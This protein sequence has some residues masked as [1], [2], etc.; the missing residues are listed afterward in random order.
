M[1][2]EP[3]IAAVRAEMSES[4][5]RIRRQVETYRRDLFLALHPVPLEPRPRVNLL[6]FVILV[7]RPVVRERSS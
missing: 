2:V 6:A 5:D 7:R 4:F 3:D 1:T